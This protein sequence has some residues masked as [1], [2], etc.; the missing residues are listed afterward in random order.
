MIR[1]FVKHNLS[2]HPKQYHPWPPSITNR[3]IGLNDNSIAW[4]GA[5]Y[6]KR[7]PADENSRENSSGGAGT[8]G[9]Q[10]PA[11]QAILVVGQVGCKLRPKSRP[12]VGRLTYSLTAPPIKWGR[13]CFAHQFARV[14]ELADAP[15][16]GSGAVRRGGSSPPSRNLPSASPRKAI[17]PGR[18]F[19]AVP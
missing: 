4:W 18:S 1:V 6:S 17:R 19:P 3:A 2:H 11:A 9:I 5:R 10:H 14:A 7:G 12:L 13:S 15:D 8:T 16:L